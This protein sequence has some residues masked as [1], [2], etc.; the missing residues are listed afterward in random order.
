MRNKF[1]FLGFLGEFKDER[2]IQGY[3]RAYMAKVYCKRYASDMPPF[4][5]FIS[6][7]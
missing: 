4:F 1:F 6:L 2:E 5:L 3:E 7:L